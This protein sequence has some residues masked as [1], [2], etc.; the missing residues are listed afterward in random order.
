MKFLI[1]IIVAFLISVKVYSTDAVIHYIGDC[2]SS[3]TLQNYS[4]INY[5]RLHGMNL[6]S[7]TW[8]GPSMPDSIPFSTILAFM[9]DTDSAQ[10]ENQ[11]FR[12]FNERF[13]YIT[14]GSN[15]YSLN[16]EVLD[17]N[18]VYTA[19]KTKDSVYVFELIDKQTNIPVAIDYGSNRTKTFSLGTNRL[20]FIVSLD[21]NN[22]Y[23]SDYIGA[24][25]TFTAIYNYGNTYLF[26]I[27][28]DDRDDMLVGFKY[29][30]PK[31]TNFYQKF[32]VPKP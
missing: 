24:N 25:L 31:L 27:T 32:I 16:P 7:S 5:M 6:G 13:Y 9:C 30:S 1:A 28:D 10:S 21:N 2:E 12:T 22:P 26:E 29:L 8:T 20:N 15:T 11:E 4:T 14:C 23:Q 3:D 17:V 19:T 18:L